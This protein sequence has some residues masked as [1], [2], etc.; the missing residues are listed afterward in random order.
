MSN[1]SIEITGQQNYDFQDMVCIYLI[2]IVLSKYSES[3]NSFFAEQAD[4]ED[5]TMIIDGRTIEVQVKGSTKPL[6]L[7]DLRTTYPIFQIKVLII[8]YLKDSY[9]MIG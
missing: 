6:T 1:N 4:S 2:L 8:P 5:A 3:D 9:Q 7:K